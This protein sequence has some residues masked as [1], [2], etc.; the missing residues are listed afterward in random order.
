MLLCCLLFCLKVQGEDEVPYKTKKYKSSKSLKS[1]T[2]QPKTFESK[3][4]PPP[5]RQLTEAKSFEP[6]PLEAKSL[7]AKKLTAEPTV[8]STSLKSVTP[9]QG[10]APSE[11]KLVDVKKY[12][13]GETD[14]PSTITAKP[15]GLDQEKKIYQPST[16]QSPHIIIERPDARNPLLEPR[17][18][19][20]APEETLDEKDDPK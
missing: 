5:T 15:G 8:S 13:P 19:I 12:V 18:G 16:N 2:Y 11:E 6:K 3:A 10:N 20:K 17:Q 9:F 7:E 4:Q 1:N 14:H